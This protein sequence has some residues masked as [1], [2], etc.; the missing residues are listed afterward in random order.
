MNY[1]QSSVIT[2]LVARANL[3][4]AMSSAITL[5]FNLDKLSFIQWA[6]A[7]MGAYKFLV[8]AVYFLFLA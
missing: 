6:S 1:I 8:Y 7:Q 4:K 5:A 3:P 2:E